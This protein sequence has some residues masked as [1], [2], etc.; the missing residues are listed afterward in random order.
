MF[1]IFFFVSLYMQQVLHYS[2]IQA[3]AAF[4]PW[5]LLITVIAPTSGRLSDR[6]GPRW[7]MGTGMLLLAATLLIFSRLGT[8]SSFWALL[9]GLLTGGFGMG[10]AMTPTTAAA[11]GSVAVDKAGIGSA[12]LNSMRQLGGSLGIAV[13]GAIVAHWSQ[14]SAAAGN[15]ASVAFVDGF[16][17]ALEVA[18]GI[19]LVGAVVAVTVVRPQRR[20]ES[21]A[22]VEAAA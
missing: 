11:M 17:V 21:R 3:G 7:L 2:A 8:H 10:L 20:A 9:P 16:R 18:A 14:K 13:M 15:P 5:T 4:L 6:V 19:A 1:G 12:V 22:A